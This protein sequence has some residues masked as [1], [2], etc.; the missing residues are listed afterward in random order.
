MLRANVPGP[1]TNTLTYGGVPNFPYIVQYATNLS[2]SPWFTLSTNAPAA[3]AIG[4]ALDP[5]AT[6]P[7]RFYRVGSQE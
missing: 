1:H 7:Q 3:N 6:D 4:L 2:G 5:A